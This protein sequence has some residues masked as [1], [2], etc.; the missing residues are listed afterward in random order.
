MLRK[1]LACA[2]AIAIGADATRGVKRK[3]SNSALYNGQRNSYFHDLTVAAPNN[4]KDPELLEYFQSGAEERI[5]LSSPLHH[6]NEALLQNLYESPSTANRNLGDEA[7]EKYQYNNYNKDEIHEHNE[8][9]ITEDD[10]PTY[11]DDRPV[12]S[13]DDD[14]SSEIAWDS[15]EAGTAAGTWATI[16][17]IDAS[18]GAIPTQQPTSMGSAF[19]NDLDNYEISPLDDE[20]HDDYYTDS[21]DYWDNRINLK[22]SLGVVNNKL[23]T[24]TQRTII[25]EMALSCITKILNDHS[26]IPF[27]IH[28]GIDEKYHQRDLKSDGHGIGGRMEGTPQVQGMKQSYLAD[29]ILVD[30]GVALGSHNWWEITAIYSVWKRPH[31]NMYH[32][33]YFDDD[34]DHK[35][36]DNDR[37]KLARRGEEQQQ[38]RR[39]GIPV[40]SESILMKIEGI[41]NHAFE[42]AVRNGMYWDALYD[43]DVMDESLVID[44]GMYY[45]DDKGLLDVALVGNEYELS[46][47]FCPIERPKDESVMLCPVDGAKET[48]S[49]LYDDAY[50]IPADIASSIIRDGTSEATYPQVIVESLSDIEWGDR[51]WVGFALLISTIVWT[52]LLSLTAHFVFKK[53]KTQVL[54]GNALTPNGVDDILKVGWRVYEQ[55]AQFVAAAEN[56]QPQLF[57]QIYDKGKGVGYNDENSMLQGGV[58]PAMCAPNYQQQ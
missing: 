45:E 1:G 15:W 24:D 37:R 35:E 49:S 9:L 26:D 6:I 34:D 43:V 19:W 33:D 44:S 41:C 46:G 36:K 14:R 5:P 10:D 57:L 32:D 17:P 40:Q 7:E 22:L 55:P 11:T 3:L 28:D 48:G 12:N 13:F 8:E 18:R 52:I 4:M 2:V 50:E 51:E 31:K 39:L 42:T 25:L 21:D 54:W 38:R 58:D 27:R 56:P 23:L 53:R 29:L 20:Q 30:A 47:F 16:S